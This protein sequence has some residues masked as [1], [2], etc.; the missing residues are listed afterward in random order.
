[1]QAFLNG[2]SA[3]DTCDPTVAIA[4]N[5]PSF[6]PLGQTEVTFTASD[7]DSNQSQ[8]ASTVSVVDTVG[9]EIDPAFGVSPVVLFPPNHKLVAMTVSNLVAQDAC[10]A[11]VQI[12]CSVSSNEPVNEEGD[13]NTPFDIVFAGEPIFTQSTGLRPVAMNGNV[14]SLPLQLRSERSG[15]GS[16]RVYTITCHGV[17]GIGLA[18]PSR[19]VQVSVPHGR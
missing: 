5:A 2:A 9:P 10:Q 4:S 7:D 18:G 11:N 17:D 6:F 14:G 16:G 15:R 13:G 3:Q 8:C 1:V 19:S 12:Y